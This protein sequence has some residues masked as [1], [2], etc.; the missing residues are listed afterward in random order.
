LSK[1]NPQGD[2]AGSYID[3]SG[4]THGFVLSKGKF[5]TIDVPGAVLTEASGINPRGDIV[6]DYIDSSGNDHGFLLSK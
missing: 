2:I 1:I 5:T 4:N 6:G 3:S